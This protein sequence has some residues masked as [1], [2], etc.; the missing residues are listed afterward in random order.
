M[1]NSAEPTALKELHELFSGIATTNI[2]FQGILRNE[3]PLLR[4]RY[5][6][7]SIGK[8]IKSV[9]EPWHMIFSIH[10]HF[11]CPEDYVRALGIA[12]ILCKKPFSGFLV[13]LRRT[14]IKLQCRT[15]FFVR[16]SRPPIYCNV[17]I[18]LYKEPDMLGRLTLLMTMYERC[19]LLPIALS[20]SQKQPCTVMQRPDEVMT[21]DWRSRK[22]HMHLPAAQKST[23][24]GHWDP[25]NDCTHVQ[26][27]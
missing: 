22:L 11:S 21:I 24:N 6:V 19:S 7:L 18:Q 23:T 20:D 2:E 26:C 5:H 15:D 4:S 27:N 12:L 16:E 25:G 17:L 10:E 14:K 9:V 8:L 1:G 3:H 13:Q